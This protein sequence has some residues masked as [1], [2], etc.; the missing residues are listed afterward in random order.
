MPSHRDIQSA[1]AVAFVVAAM[2]FIMLPL[3]TYNSGSVAGHVIG[4]AGAVLMAMT[5]IYPFRKRV[6]GKKGRQNPIDAHIYYG[7]IGPIL[8]VIHAGH[9]FEGAAATLTYG[10]ML[11]IVLS[12]LT[13]RYLF[14]KVNR[15]LNEQQ[16]DLAELKSLLESR[17]LEVDPQKLALYLGRSSDKK[18]DAG[19]EDSVLD[20]TAR[21]KFDQ[22]RDIALSIAETEEQVATYAAT[23]TL[24][25]RWLKVHIYLAVFLF[26]MIAVHCL[27]TLYYGWAWLK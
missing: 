13:G 16:R 9:R 5:L 1:L 6:L 25:T 23:K 2:A 18:L 10:A 24:F 12:G 3:S 7:L 19:P 26:A 17:R 27:T 14:R 21:R 22:L 15:E 8:V 11:V 20:E 4:I